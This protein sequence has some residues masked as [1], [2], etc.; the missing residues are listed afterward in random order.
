MSRLIRFL[1]VFVCAAIPVFVQAEFTVTGSWLHQKNNPTYAIATSPMEGHE[2][3]MLN[4]RCVGHNKM[5]LFL[6]AEKEFPIKSGVM[7]YFGMY[8]SGGEIE[9][10]SINSEIFV[11]L[12]NTVLFVDDF[13]GSNMIFRTLLNADKL[14]IKLIGENY[15]SDL[16]MFNTDG[17][18]DIAGKVAAN[19][20]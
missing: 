10:T 16:I 18:S 3:D 13:D 14:S 12:K 5:M 4:M 9:R 17:F 8:R 6:E 15:H 11:V 20:K 2:N 7:K 19:C 1:S